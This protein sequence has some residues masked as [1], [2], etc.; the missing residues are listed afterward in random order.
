MLA[1]MAPFMVALF[2]R[3]SDWSIIHR[4]ASSRGIS[5]PNEHTV[6]ASFDE[7]RTFDIEPEAATR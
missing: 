7:G 6:F 5:R 3:I 2:C 1:L 4:R